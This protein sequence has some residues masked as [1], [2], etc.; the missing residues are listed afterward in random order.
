MSHKNVPFKKL[1]ILLLFLQ[2]QFLVSQTLKSDIS[3]QEYST[4][5]DNVK[6]TL[7][8]IV[9][10]IKDGDVDRLMTFHDRSLNFT[11]FKPETPRQGSKENETYKRKV[12]SNIAEVYRFNLNDLKIAVYFN[13]VANVTFHSDFLLKFK[14]EQTPVAV[15]DQI[16]LLFVKNETGDWKIVHEHRSPLSTKKSNA[17]AITKTIHV[18]KANFPK[19]NAVNVLKGWGHMVVAINEVPAGTDFSPL[20]KG[21]K[22]NLCQVPHWGYLEKGSLKTTHQDHSTTTVSAGE[23]FYMPPGHTVI[24]VEDARIIDFSPEKEMLELLTDINKILAAQKN[25]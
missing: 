9:Q 13:E 12:F 23:V 8:N 6:K 5:Q 14:D 21:Q 4:S 15:N 19:G 16:T 10:S 7:N 17:A 2:A 18:A 11:G 20:L 3:N 25:Q 24:V 1:F 22:D